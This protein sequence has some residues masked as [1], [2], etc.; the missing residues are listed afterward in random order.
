VYVLIV[1]SISATGIVNLG[2]A[3]LAIKSRK[4]LI[5]NTVFYILSVVALI[6]FL[7]MALIITKVF[8]LSSRYVLALSFVMMV[9]AAFY[10]ADSFRYF[11]QKSKPS[12]KNQWLTIALLAFM[13]LSLIKN[14]LP[15]QNGYNYIQDA[16]TWIDQHKVPKKE[17]FYDD[18]R[19]RY[20]LGLPFIPDMGNDWLM[21]TSA[22]ED[23]SIQ[24]YNYLLLSFSVKDKDREKLVADKLSE[25]HE[26]KRFNSAKAKKSVVLYQRI[27]SITP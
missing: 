3:V 5:N 9:F 14:I 7:N 10:L 4:R 23:K 12:K 27:S 22:I 18:K 17:V 11:E 6:A 25:Y 26:I 16:T 20:Y 19:M 21:V 15:K 2:L 24:K 1:K 13:V 8:V